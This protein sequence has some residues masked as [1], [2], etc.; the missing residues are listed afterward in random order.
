MLTLSTL[1][2]GDDDGTIET[3]GDSREDQ[4]ICVV[5]IHDW[6]Q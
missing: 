6:Q 1:F 4:D 3:L 2:I 5:G